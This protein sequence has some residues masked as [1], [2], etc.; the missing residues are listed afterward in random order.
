ML[1]DQRDALQP[2]RAEELKRAVGSYSSS[3]GVGAYSFHPPIP[4]DHRVARGNCSLLG[5][6]GAVCGR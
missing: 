5:T 4:L 3:T 2:M 1:Q 6:D